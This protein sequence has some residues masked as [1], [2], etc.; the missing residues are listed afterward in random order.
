[1]VFLKYFL[2]KKMIIAESAV[3]YKNWTVPGGNRSGILHLSY[4]LFGGP[5]VY[6]KSIRV[7]L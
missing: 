4:Q 6:L 3:S 5:R 1:M 2:V 7:T